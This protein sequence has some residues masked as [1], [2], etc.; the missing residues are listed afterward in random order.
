MKQ[1]KKDS[2]AREWRSIQETDR[3]FL[4]QLVVDLVDAATAGEC[5]DCTCKR[6]AV[7]WGTIKRAQKFLEGA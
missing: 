1:K 4:M 7:K 2:F 3:D 6:C 5:P